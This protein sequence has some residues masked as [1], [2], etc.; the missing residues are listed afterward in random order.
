MAKRQIHLT[1]QE[2]GQ[3]REAE[4]HSDD[5][6]ARQRFQAIRLYGQGWPLKQIMDIVMAGESTIRQWAMAYRAKGL[7]GLRWQWQGQNA[8]KLTE[9]QRQQVKAR[10]H[11]YRPV[12]LHISQN[13]YWTVR[14][15]R[16]AVKEW[17]GVVYPD[18]SSYQSLLHACGLSY[19][20]AAKV[21][22]SH[23][24]AAEIAQFESELEKK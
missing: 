22:R 7:E 3:L 8:N 23:P 9:A 16:V 17:C 11:D 12:D 14:D 5:K 2:I 4:T 15:V 19:Q 10:L 24:S 21:Y 6:H 1:E 13:E 18:E 20:R